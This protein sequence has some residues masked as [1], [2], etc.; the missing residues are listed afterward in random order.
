LK[1]YVHNGFKVGPNYANPQAPVA[2]HWIDAED[3]RVRSESADFSLWW[4][5]FGDSTLNDLI[6][7]AYHQ[8][9]TVKE[10][11]F[12]VLAA[13]AQLGIAEGEFFP[14]TQVMNGS[15]TSR[16]VSG[17]VANRVATP[18]LWFGQFD[19]GFGLA[20]ELD[21]WGRFRRA[22]EAA[23][24]TL[25]ASVDNY[26][27]VIVT[28]LGDVAATYVEIRALQQQITN[29]TQLNDLQRQSLEVAD[30]KF[31]GGQTSKVDVNQAQSDVAHT[32]ATI[33]EFRIRLRHATNRLCVLL[34]QPPEAL[35]SKL[36]TTAI[37]KLPPE[38]I[39][40]IPTDLLRRRP[41]VRRAEREAA[42]QSARIGVA[43]ADFYP[44]I[45]LNGI[46]GWSAQDLGKLFAS[47]SLRESVGPA[48]QWPILNYGRILNNVHLQDARFQELVV[49]YQQTALTAAREVEDGLVTYL[50]SQIRVRDE[51]EAVNA[52]TE[53]YREVLSQYK[54]GLVDYNRVALIQERLVERQ[55][56]LTDAQKD[57]ALGLIQV[58]RALG[59][60]WEIRCVQGT[61]AVEQNGQGPVADQSRPGPVAVDH[62]SHS[63]S[64]PRLP[65]AHW[66]NRIS[67]QQ[68][69]SEV[70]VPAVTGRPT[71][72]G[73]TIPNPA[74]I[75]PSAVVR[76]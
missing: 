76:P 3:T 10:A 51:G 9:L 73:A 75:K 19:Y 17:N 74:V 59:G 49:A 11:G 60:G 72:A 47:G 23:E 65:D 2:P 18:Q 27:E 45:S 4:T 71:T 20:W 8:N 63:S 41:D 32:R 22:I 46:L 7:N 44:Q 62:N 25:D 66:S 58:Y 1:E 38:A 40:G 55:V 15:A 14:Q 56:F 70:E 35:D 5:V 61:V 43:E 50:R 31:K 52:L 67:A 24:A 28:L 54:N 64:S 30:A 21:F 12:R 53:A 69:I 37:P 13:R 42:A 57:A 29:L 33:E 26:D 48:F 6:Q 36:G 68:V 34:G 39:V 16:G